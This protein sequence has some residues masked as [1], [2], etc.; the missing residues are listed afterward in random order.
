MS[1]VATDASRMGVTLQ[2]YNQVV[3][4]SQA[5]INETL[6]R[7]FSVLDAD[8]QL[9]L[10]KAKAG[11]A[12]ISA[13]VLAPRI[14]LIDK[15]DGD[16]ALYI[17]R[18]GEGTF[19]AVNMDGDDVEVL[20]YP[21]NG[22]ELAFNV[23]FA[24]K[25]VKKLPQNI[26]QQ[27]PLAGGYSVKQLMINFGDATRIFQLD[28]NRTKYPVSDKD[29]A[30]LDTSSLK[31]AL[32][33]FANTYLE[34]KLKTTDN[35]NILG[36]AVELTEKPKDLKP[37]FLPTACKVQIVGHR[38]GGDAKSFQQGNPYNAFCFT[39]MTDGRTMP[40]AELK[41]SGNWFYE[42]LGGTMAISRS[43][44][45]DL[46][47]V[48]NIKDAHV[49]A[50]E[51]SHYVIRA[52]GKPFFGRD[53]WYLDDA[54]PMREQLCGPFALPSELPPLAFGTTYTCSKLEH[55]NNEELSP[56]AKC[57][58]K[59]RTTISTSA[60]PT[61]RKGEIVVTQKIDVSWEQGAKLSD[62]FKAI[63]L[64]AVF[65]D[66][67]NVN[68]TGSIGLTTKTTIS[69]NAVTSTGSLQVTSD[70]QVTRQ[71]YRALDFNIGGIGSYLPGDIQRKI[72]ELPGLVSEEYRRMK[73]E[74]S[75]WLQGRK[76]VFK[77]VAEGIQQDLN[78]SSKF[79]FP[80][81]GTFD[82]KD[83]LFSDEGNLMVGLVYR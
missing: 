71:E 12:S 49:K 78:N 14:E 59:P 74:L 67:F 62:Y 73:A 58:F 10:F 45:W 30:K 16:G 75:A 60:A 50:V 25:P 34:N 64:S 13:K 52:M 15:D 38:A 9:D 39:E 66:A 44:F 35:H 7:H 28:P 36:Y 77:T 70:T 24:F 19:K 57:F 65:A 8:D 53:M 6:R 5:N 32:Q 21:T 1:I 69:M 47:M 68:L 82:I 72:N 51:A 17:L 2:G 23:D 33:M 56:V 55:W 83:P 3:A 22:W 27:V 81:N 11:A 79:V 26:E 46:F 31:V 40:G 41:Y 61:K 63:P 76:D 20:Q 37:T 54:E 80:G 4:L 43:T 48:P 29:K 42:S 18:L